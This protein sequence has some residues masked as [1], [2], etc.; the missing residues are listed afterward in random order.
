MSMSIIILAAGQ[1]KR[2]YSAKPKVLH[3][4]AG[5]PLL[6]HVYG[7][8]SP[9]ADGQLFVVYGHGGERLRER[10][11]HLAVHWIEQTE[12][13]G[14][15]HAVAQALPSIPH[16]DTVLVLYGDVPLIGQQTLRR[17]MR[18]SD[19]GGLGLLTVE[20]DDPTGYGR[21]VRDKRGAVIRIVEHKDASDE[22]LKIREINT[23]FLAV[24]AERLK[25]WLDRL[26]N[27]NA[28]GE[29]YLT[30]IVQM[31]VSENLS[32]NTV[33]PDLVHEVLGVNNPAQLATL[34]RYYQ[35]IQAQ[36]LMTEGVTIIDPQR[37]DLRGTL[38]TGRDCVIDV[39]VV[40]EGQV[41][42][43]DNVKIGPNVCIRDARLGDDITVFAN[44][45]IEEAQIGRG[46]RIGPFARLRPETSLAENVHIGNF[47]EIKKSDVASGTKINHLSYVGDSDVGERVN[48]GAGTITCN[49][50]GANKHRTIIGDDVFIGSN[51]QLIA[52]VTIG[53]GATIGAGTTVTK[54]V[55]SGVLA[56]SRVDQK[57]IAHWRRPQKKK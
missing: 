2:M 47:V 5:K 26:D 55:P 51:T 22:Q 7:T 32:I 17:L 38:L 52:P 45:V 39:N 34:E 13:L 41:S 29:Y 4:L 35:G 10:L 8:A 25:A 42:L 21:I 30:D 53:D 24:A 6:E 9:L 16:N 12:Q 15:G 46:A 48:I 23:G 50:D 44:C 33:G 40:L 18:A 56:L 54:E 49:Y 3:E 28:Q 37:F 19:N 11:G 27:R 1:G 20:L 36:R 31:A 43:G 14:T 57:V